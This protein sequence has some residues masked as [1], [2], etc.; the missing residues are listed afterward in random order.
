MGSNQSTYLSWLCGIITV[1]HVGR[2]LWSLYMVFCVIHNV[3]LSWAMHNQSLSYLWGG[4][5]GPINIGIGNISNDTHFNV[6]HN[7]LQCYWSYD[8]LWLLYGK[9]S[10]IIFQ[11]FGICLTVSSAFLLP[12]LI[13]FR[14]YTWGIVNIH[15]V[16]LELL[17]WQ[18]VCRLFHLCYVKRL[19]I[20]L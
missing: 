14:I 3:T 8:V 9:G 4:L 19:H 1:M 11:I 10:S 7:L 20:N 15:M 12:R 17:G 16:S 5:I 2:Y 6:L 13:G 18:T